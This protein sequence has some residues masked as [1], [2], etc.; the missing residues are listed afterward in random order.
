MRSNI[1]DAI[2]NCEACQRLQAKFNSD[3]AL[4]SI[5]VIP[6]AWHSLGI[7]VVGPFPTSVTGKRYVII[8]IDYF[9]KWV[10]AK[11]MKTQGLAETAVFMTE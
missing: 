5:P 8:A 3:P 7:D 11:A 6:T 2:D 4:H 10:E 1:K 9:T